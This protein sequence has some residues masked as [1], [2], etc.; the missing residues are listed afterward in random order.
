ALFIILEKYPN[1]RNI[2]SI[3]QLMTIGTADQIVEKALMEGME[4]EMNYKDI[5]KMAKER[6]EKLS[7]LMPKTTVPMLPREVVKKE[8]V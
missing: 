7:E 4:L 2:M 3:Q 6:V 8:I 1:V 5:Y